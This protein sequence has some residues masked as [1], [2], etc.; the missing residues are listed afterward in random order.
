MIN[1]NAQ[2]HAHWLEG[3]SWVQP[4]PSSQPEQTIKY[5]VVKMLYDL[6]AKSLDPSIAQT[7]STLNIMLYRVL[8]PSEAT[9]N[10]N[11]THSII[12][13]FPPA[14]TLPFLCF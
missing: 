12:F 2:W 10:D 14:A 7:P 4:L 6:T 9:Y 8:H 5:T 11:S 1:M 13:S 3:V